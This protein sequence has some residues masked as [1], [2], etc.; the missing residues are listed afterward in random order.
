MRI[1][2]VRIFGAAAALALTATAPA[3]SQGPRGPRIP[4]AIGGRVVVERGGALRFGWPGVYFEGRFRGTGLRVVIDKGSDRLRL[5]IDGVEKA[6]FER[7]GDVDALISGL[8]A[9]EHRF[10][11]EKLAESQND[12]TRLIG[13]YPLDG[14]KPLSPP[15]PTGRGIEF[16]GDSYT[17]G[18]GDTAPGHSCSQAQIHDSTDTQQAFGPLVA[19]RLGAE[20][21]V[22]AF[23]GRGVVRNYGGSS[24]GTAMPDLYPRLIPGDPAPREDAPGSWRPQV[25]VINL[26]TND[27]S[28]PV[29]AGEAWRD[30]AALHAAYQARYIA[31]ARAL[32]A[33]QPQARLILM[34]S[35]VFHAD[36]TRIAGA[37]G[38]AAPGRVSAIHFTGLDL[39]G[40]DWHPSLRDHQRLADMLQAEIIRIRPFGH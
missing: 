7:A 28:T 40:C 36:V 4:V 14:G 16:I 18:Y 9:G 19:R 10:R 32:L 31:F 6:R 20:Y 35:D 13:F 15:A 38:K 24:P 17:V 2:A 3:C 1:A 12:S 33:K 26:G 21:R 5:L 30:D 23:S 37:L 27:F 34:G 11:L 25:I 39:G 22:I 29:H 8:G